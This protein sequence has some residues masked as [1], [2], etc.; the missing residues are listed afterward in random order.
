MEA[1]AQSLGWKPQ[2]CSHCRGSGIWKT[3]DPNAEDGFARERCGCA[4]S[5]REWVPIDG[6]SGLR[7]DEEM[8][9]LI[10]QHRASA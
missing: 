8:R 4:P 3:E 6:S 7:N 1:E 10:E 2:R 5:G 9:A